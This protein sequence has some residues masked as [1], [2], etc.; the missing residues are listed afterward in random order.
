MDTCGTDNFNKQVCYW[1]TLWFS[2]GSFLISKSNSLN[3]AY[4]SFYG[5]SES[6]D[7]IWWYDEYDKIDLG[8][9]LEF[10]GWET[11]NG[12]RVFSREFEKGYVYV[13]PIGC[14]DT[15]FV[16]GTTFRRLPPGARANAL[17]HEMLHTLGLR[18]NPPTSTEISRRVQARCGW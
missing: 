18:E 6:A 5:N 15:V 10:Y 8:K 9:A 2:L 1:Q 4:F 12:V 11:F 13:N 3:N 7:R 14:T 17:I 16:C